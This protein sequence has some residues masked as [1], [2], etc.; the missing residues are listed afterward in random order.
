[1]EMNKKFKVDM[2]I[3]QAVNNI[4]YKNMPA[5]LEIRLLCEQLS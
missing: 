2:P 4:L 3:L 1:M 5:A